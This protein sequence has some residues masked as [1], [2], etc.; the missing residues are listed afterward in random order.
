MAKKTFIPNWYV[1]RKNEIINE[2]IKICIIMV[3]I[4]NI[5]LLSFIV[6]ISNKT[7]SIQQQI[8]N[9][10]NSISTLDT[11]KKDVVTIEKYKQLN[12]FFKE[13]NMNY[14][15]VIITKDN[16]EVEIEVESY[17]EYVNVIRC[18]ENQY[19]IKKLIPCGENEGN[20]NLKLM[21]EV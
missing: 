15:K 14:K 12:N 11:V 3:L 1:D 9:E 8:S 20:F 21:L 10:N 2:K 6:N 17:E 4:I 16:F 18:I 7:K 5:F 19:L 13:N